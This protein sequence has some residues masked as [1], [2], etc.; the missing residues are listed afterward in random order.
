MNIQM[1]LDI[2]YPLILKPK[3]CGYMIVVK[4][5]VKVDEA[6]TSKAST[7]IHNRE[8]SLIE[9]CWLFDELEGALFALDQFATIRGTD[10]PV[11]WQYE[12]RRIEKNKVYE[13]Q[14]VLLVSWK[15]K[16]NV[17]N[18]C[19]GTATGEYAFHNGLACVPT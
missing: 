3:A 14:N 1:P 13:P 11:G 2:Q 6:L 19:P 5:N 12:V 4:P 18:Q 15:R 7:L 9:K 10:L 17:E 16:A 8:V